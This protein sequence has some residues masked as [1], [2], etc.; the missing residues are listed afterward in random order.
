MNLRQMEESF[1]LLDANFWPPKVSTYI[2]ESFFACLH[3][4]K[5]CSAPDS[6]AARHRGFEDRATALPSSSGM[7]W[8][9]MGCCKCQ[10]TASWWSFSNMHPD[11]SLPYMYI[12]T[13]IVIIT[14]V[15]TDTDTDT[16]THTQCIIYIYTHRIVDYF[17][18]SSYIFII[19]R[20]SSPSFHAFP[21]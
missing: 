20:P 11:P 21:P 19:F 8:Q 3:H 15:Y 16:H 5:L 9:P 10:R 17:L 18:I 6:K 2:Y 7:P 12:Y 13:Y 14:N 1:Q 4:L